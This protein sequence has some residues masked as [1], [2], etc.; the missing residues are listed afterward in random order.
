MQLSHAVT[1]IMVFYCMHRRTDHPALHALMATEPSSLLVRL[2]MP[3]A[4][5]A[6]LHA[7]LAL[8]SRSPVPYHIHRSAQGHLAL[9]VTLADCATLAHQILECYKE[10]MSFAA[11]PHLGE[12]DHRFQDMAQMEILVPSSDT[13]L[14]RQMTR[15]GPC[16]SVPMRLA[17]DRMQSLPPALREAF[18]ASPALSKLMLSHA[19]YPMR[20][21]APSQRDTLHTAAPSTA[22][23]EPAA[24]VTQ[25]EQKGKGVTAGRDN[26]TYVDFTKGRS[27][28]R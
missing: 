26:I 12:L 13:Q 19:L 14:T 7:E 25:S 27:P 20:H 18:P 16:A 22:T 28:R 6:A 11:I 2:P 1:M 10:D 4:T 24:L 3:E 15:L 23:T 21:I 8:V 17:V 9:E 5:E